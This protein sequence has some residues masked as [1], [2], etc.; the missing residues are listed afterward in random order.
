MIYFP[1][2]VQCGVCTIIVLIGIV[3]DDIEYRVFLFIVIWH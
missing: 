1:V 3:A 2:Y